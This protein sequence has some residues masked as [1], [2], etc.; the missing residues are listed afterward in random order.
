MMECNVQVVKQN[1]TG[2]QWIASEAWTL[3]DGLQT[4]TFMPFL[5]GTLG[6]AIRRGEIAGLLNFLLKIHPEQNN[7]NNNENNMVRV[8]L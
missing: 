2:L 1:L 8:F 6:I 4:P 7:K 5:G 3:L